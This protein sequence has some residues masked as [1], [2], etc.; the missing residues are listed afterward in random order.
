[1]PGWYWV[2][3]VDRS[4]ADP[5]EGIADFD[6]SRWFRST[7]ADGNTWSIYRDVSG[8]RL[9]E[10]V[11]VTPVPTWL[12]ETLIGHGGYAPRGLEGLIDDIRDWLE[13]HKEA[14]R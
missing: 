2:R 13:N 8:D 6:G 14:R 10:A 1:V 7:H 4:E 5:V 9:D 12:I 3:G 11:P